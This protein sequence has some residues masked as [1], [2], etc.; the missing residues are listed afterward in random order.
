MT[1]D[2]LVFFDLETGGLDPKR[3][4]ITEI[5]AIAVFTESLQAIEELHYRVLFDPN[6]CDPKAL[7]INKYDA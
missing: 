6:E 4:P 3:H 2:K 7:S 1:I 5:G